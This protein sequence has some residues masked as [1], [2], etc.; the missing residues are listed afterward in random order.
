MRI[1]VTFAL[2]VEFAPWRAMRQFRAG[3]WG[4]ADAQL[5]EIGGAEVGVVLTGAGPR[6]A[7]LEISKAI[8]EEY[9][10]TNLCVSSG[11]A[12]ALRPQYQ[13]AQILAPRTVFSE[14][15]ANDPAS[16]L[17][18][19]SDSLLAFAKD[20]GATVVD[21]FY[22]AERAIGR[23]DEKRHLG[24]AADAVEMESFEIL[25]AAAA[26]GIPAV[27]VRAVS[28][29]V[30]EDLP[31]DMNEIFSD[32]G[33]VSIPRV[34]GQVARNPQSLPGLVRLGKNSRAAAESLA[35]FLESYM[36]VLAERIAPL[37]TN[38]KAAG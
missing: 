19:S 1:L 3:K 13:L 38:S 18:D 23:A 29:T 2:E 35:R 27:A 25:F 20:C 10:S 34:L 28:D 4:G 37:E 6:Q 9:D 24:A 17:I 8:G 32:E 12:G 14:R 30:D 11:L 5:T 16:N 22:S 33:Q 21:R 36:Q 15:A 26:E 31:L 7:K